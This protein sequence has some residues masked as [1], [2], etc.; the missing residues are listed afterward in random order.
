[1]KRGIGFWGKVGWGLVAVAGA[2]ALGVVALRRGEPVN[3]LWLVVATGCVY[4]IGYRFHSAW[5]MATVLAIEPQRKTPS[6][7]L[8]DGRDFVKTNRWVVFG[9]HF[10][11][12]A[13]PGPLVGPV[14]AAQF[15]YLPGFLWILIGAVLGGA[16][17][18]SLILWLSVRRSGKSVGQMIREEVG[19]VAGTLAV[20]GLLGIITMLMAVL[21]LVVVRALAESPWGLF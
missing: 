7:R 12:I 8:A 10:A 18:D 14:L 13:G 19:P 2:V 9:H 17:H 6:E 11:A 1:M 5:L 4:A 3:A 15:G 21:A 20:V 16:V